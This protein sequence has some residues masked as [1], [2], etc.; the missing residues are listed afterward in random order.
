MTK[1]RNVGRGGKRPR[2]GPKPQPE[3]RRKGMMIYL[4]PSA[5]E[6][7]AGQREGDEPLGRTAA[8]IIEAQAIDAF[9]PPSQGARKEKEEL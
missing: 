7:L 6:Y 2:S 5:I 1:S 4:L 3:L 8:R 9:T